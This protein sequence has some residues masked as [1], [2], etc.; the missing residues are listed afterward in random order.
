MSGKGEDDVEEF[1][2]WWRTDWWSKGI[3]WSLISLSLWAETLCRPASDSS[4]SSIV[5]RKVA[6][7]ACSH[8]RQEVSSRSQRWSVNTDD[9]SGSFGSSESPSSHED[10]RTW[11]KHRHQLLC[12]QARVFGIAASCFQ[13]QACSWGIRLGI[14]SM[15]GNIAC[16]DGGC[17]RDIGAIGMVDM[18]WYESGFHPPYCNRFKETVYLSIRLFYNSPLITWYEFPFAFLEFL[19]YLFQVILRAVQWYIHR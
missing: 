7:V 10:R 5:H 13:T 17:W 15:T 14:L 11:S 6:K 2:E 8:I 3:C 4:S 9:S 19:G 16:K 1:N 18:H 12:H